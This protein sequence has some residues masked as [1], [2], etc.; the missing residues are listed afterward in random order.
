MKRTIAIILCAVMLLAPMSAFAASYEDCPSPMF[1]WGISVSATEN[2]NIGTKKLIGGLD[3]TG[4]PIPANYSRTHTFS[5]SITTTGTI[6]S[7]VGANLNVKTGAVS[8][9]LAAEI[10]DSYSFS[11]NFTGS[12]TET[13]STTVPARKNLNLYSQAVGTKLTVY[14]I[15]HSFFIHV[16]WADGTFGIPQGQKFVAEVTPKRPVQ[17]G[18]VQSVPSSGE[19]NN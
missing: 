15:K 1:G 4:S 3:N 19:I 2:Q 11:E 18:Q 10:N 17:N 14:A 13:Y 6:A 5:H 7:K 12:Y 8:G 16:E 9:G